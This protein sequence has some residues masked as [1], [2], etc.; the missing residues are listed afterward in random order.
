LECDFLQKTLLELVYSEKREN[1][2]LL[3]FCQEVS[4]TILFYH[5]KFTPIVELDFENIIHQEKD[6]F[7]FCFKEKGSFNK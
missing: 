6:F 7:I 3:E 5:D 4:E 2:E 1:I